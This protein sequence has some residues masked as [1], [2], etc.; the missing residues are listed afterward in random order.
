[1]EHNTNLTDY[2]NNYIR[3]SILSKMKS[4]QE[5]NSAWSIGEILQLKINNNYYVPLEV[6]F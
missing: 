6:E 1:M 5:R 3:D 4:L 2:F